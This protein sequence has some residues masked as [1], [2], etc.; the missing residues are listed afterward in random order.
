MSK[1]MFVQMPTDEKSAQVNV[2]QMRDS[3]SRT[4]IQS[5]KM[6]TFGRRKT[7]PNMNKPQGTGYDGE[8]DSVN[9]LG[10]IYSKIMN[11]NVITR[12]LLYILP[13][14]IA[15]AIPLALF[16]TIYPNARAGGV[17]LLGLFIW[18]EVMWGALWLTKLL[19]QMLPYIFQCVAPREILPQTV[20]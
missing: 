14:S 10:R 15:L 16:A 2:S 9:R 13:L 7:L 12:N 18:L 4:E 1:D 8:Q 3:E 20:R 11:F 17:K 6:T 5:P 19:A